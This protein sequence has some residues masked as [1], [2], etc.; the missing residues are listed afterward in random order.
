MKKIILVRHGKS[1]WDKP[2]L[3][4]HKRPLA[5]RGLRDVPVMASRL[6]ARGINPDL[7]LSSS[8][9]RAIK[10]AELTAATFGYPKNE[11][12]SDDHLYHASPEKILKIIHHL[13]DRYETILIFGHNPGFN[14]L[15]E[16]LGG[17]IDNLPTSA[18]YG[19]KFDT[20]HWSE[21][22]NEN[23]KFWFY[24]FPKRKL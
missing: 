3:A 16:L 10:T 24:D 17:S 1:A 9:E 5:E 23:S 11:I 15:I 8:A 2:F 7:F 12:I 13:K 20:D 14:E 6:K 4:D 18:H 21:I 19:F 22:S